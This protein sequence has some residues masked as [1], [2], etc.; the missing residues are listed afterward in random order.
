MKVAEV[1]SKYRITEEKGVQNPLLMDLVAEELAS[2]YAVSKQSVLIRMQ[3]VGFTEAKSISQFDSLNKPHYDIE[4]DD[5]FFVYSTN[6]DLRRL[7]DE[8]LFVYAQNHFVIN[9]PLYVFRTEDRALELTQ[10]AIE[11]FDTCALSFSWIEAPKIDHPHAPVVLMH[12]ANASQQVSAFLPKENQAAI[13]LSEELQRKREE[14]EKQTS[15][16]RL[17]NPQKTAW[18]LM[19]EI[20]TQRGMSSPH[21]CN[22]TSIDEMVYRRAVN[23]ADTRPSIETIVAFSCGLDLDIQTAEKIMQL[24]SHSF[25][26]SDLHRAYKFCIPATL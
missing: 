26:E 12:R 5:A 17:A 19:R 21:F 22:L 9:D 4:E 1:Y 3:E 24:A 16:Y 10:Y 11:H 20:I 2:F 23:G 25:D 15:S 6:A 14:F 7:M 13:V 8:G 18:Q